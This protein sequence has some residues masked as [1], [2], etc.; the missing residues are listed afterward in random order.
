M[1][2]PA[3]FTPEQEAILQLYI[4]R[5]LRRDQD[6]WDQ[7]ALLAQ[8]LQTAPKQHTKAFL[9]AV[10]KYIGE[11]TTAPQRATIY[12]MAAAYERIP[13]NLRGIL[14]PSKALAVA[15]A[16]M[17]QPPELVE[18][19]AS[20]AVE[21]SLPALREELHNALGARMREDLAAEKCPTCQRALPHKHKGGE[22][23][24]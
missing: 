20:R 12:R 24:E 10:T 1:S 21:L 11:S 18:E 5:D 9:A 16:T 13:D 19:W 2:N 6:R 15:D 8:L 23:N 3:P 7:Y 17:Q 22:G 14:H 4:Q